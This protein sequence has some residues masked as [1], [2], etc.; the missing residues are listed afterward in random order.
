[1]TFHVWM[2]P[3][4][5]Y[6]NSTASTA[7]TQW[8][9]LGGELPDNA[10]VGGDNNEILTLA[11]LNDESVGTY[12]CSTFTK[13]G[14]YRKLFIVSIQ[15]QHLVS[16][17]DKTDIKMLPMTGFDCNTVA[18]VELARIS[19]SYVRKCK[20]SMFEHYSPQPSEI[21]K[22]DL[23]NQQRTTQFMAKRCEIHLTIRGAIKIGNRE[24]LG[25]CPNRVGR[26]KKNPEMSQFQFGNFE[27]RGGYLFFKNV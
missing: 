8:E 21:R 20:R 16:M 11:Q 26:G 13:E 19:L 6:C 24:N 17:T 22:W 7:Y 12:A 27:S 3:L 4:R 5:L 18:P 10:E 23:L 1:M 14:N 25:Q 9:R 2:A 15:R